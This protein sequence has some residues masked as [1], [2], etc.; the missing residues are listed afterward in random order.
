MLLIVDYPEFC[1]QRSHTS[2]LKKF[3]LVHDFDS[4]PYQMQQASP[5]QLLSFWLLLPFFLLV[6]FLWLLRGCS[7]GSR[8]SHW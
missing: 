7:S 6:L 2:R 1:A 4:S 8:R 3:G 5:L